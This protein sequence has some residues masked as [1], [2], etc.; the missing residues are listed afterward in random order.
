M[1]AICGLFSVIEQYL[2]TECLEQ[3]FEKN[4]KVIPVQTVG[5]EMVD[6]PS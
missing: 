5:L 3:T 4:L 1:L 2:T 6:N